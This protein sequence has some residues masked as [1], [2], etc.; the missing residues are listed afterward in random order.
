MSLTLFKW[1]EG[2]TMPRLH[3]FGK[4]SGHSVSLLYVYH[5][6]YLT[7]IKNT[8]KYVFSFKNTL[9]YFEIASCLMLTL[10][11]VKPSPLN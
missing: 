5:F 2:H 3:S 6:N 11:E 1:E 10:H 9:M 8:V 7:I 4:V